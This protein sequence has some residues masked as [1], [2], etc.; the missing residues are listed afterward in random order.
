MIFNAEGRTSNSALIF[1][2]PLTYKVAYF[3]MSPRLTYFQ[4]TKAKFVD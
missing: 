1:M 4:Y 3:F 2:V